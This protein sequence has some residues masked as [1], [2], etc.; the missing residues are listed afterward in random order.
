M[1][2]LFWKTLALGIDTQVL[3]LSGR[4]IDPNEHVVLIFLV[5]ETR[6]ARHNGR[7][8]WMTTLPTIGFTVYPPYVGQSRNNII[9][10]AQIITICIAVGRVVVL[11]FSWFN[12][13][14]YWEYMTSTVMTGLN[15]TF[16]YYIMSSAGAKTLSGAYIPDSNRVMIIIL[17]YYFY[18]IKIIL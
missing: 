8:S 7:R 10:V 17:Y 5:I 9:R 15:G 13:V 18:G 6:I 4:Y 1:L 2:E 16:C 3:A 11:M 14:V 12:R